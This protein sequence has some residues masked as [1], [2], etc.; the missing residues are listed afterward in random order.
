MSDTERMPPLAPIVELQ[1]TCYACPSQWEGKLQDGTELYV[2]YRFGTLRVDLDGET[3]AHAHI[4]DAMDGAM[5]IS[6]ML[7]YT[8]LQL[9]EGIRI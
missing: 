8:G 5:S 6:E 4:G 3:V 1:Q 7:H 9:A 2:R